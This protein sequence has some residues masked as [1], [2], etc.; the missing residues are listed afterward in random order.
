M[1]PQQPKWK[2]DQKQAANINTTKSQNVHTA[3]SGNISTITVADVLSGGSFLIDTGAEESVFPASI[4]ER[5]RFEDI[6]WWL[7]MAQPF[8][9]MEK[10]ISHY[11]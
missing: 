7:P 1:A 10:G 3:P 4:A 9:L 2:R 8:L 6:V 11:N 5:K